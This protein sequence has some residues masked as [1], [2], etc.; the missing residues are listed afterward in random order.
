MITIMKRIFYIALA[1][2]LVSCSSKPHISERFHNVLAEKESEMVN[3]YWYSEENIKSVT[4]P[5]ALFIK[6]INT[7]NSFSAIY[8]WENGRL[9]EIK[10]NG[11]YIYEGVVIP[12]SLHLKFTQLGE[13]VYQRYKYD[14]HIVLV[15]NIQLDNYK[16][17]V[18]IALNKARQLKENEA[19]FYQGYLSKEG[20]KNCAN[21]VS[22]VNNKT[23][24]WGHHLS[25]IVLNRLND[26]NSYV[27][28]IGQE[29]TKYTNVNDLISLSEED[30][31]CVEIPNL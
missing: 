13:L 14:D 5:S 11:S 10:Q 15:N 3:I 7:H 16:Q 24:N 12:F 9:S 4:L 31:P 29:H 22:T 8:S 1:T 17:Q 26:V 18:E 2:A 20:F 30:T 28:F 25:H 27:S 19:Y 21:D 6:S 23:L